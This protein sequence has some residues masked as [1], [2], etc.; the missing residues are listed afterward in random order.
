MKE[1]ALALIC[2]TLGMPEGTVLEDMTFAEIPQ[3]DSL[4]QLMIAS[5]LQEELGLTIPM[6]KLLE[7]TDVRGLLAAAGVTE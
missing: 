3:W 5:A 4:M 6:E 2:R 7:I 1:K